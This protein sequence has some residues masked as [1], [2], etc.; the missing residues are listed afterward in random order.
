[1]IDKG[2]FEYMVLEIIRCGN[3]ENKIKMVTPHKLFRF[4]V[5]TY[6][7]FKPKNKHSIRRIEYV[8]ELGA[9]ELSVTSMDHTGTKEV[10]DLEL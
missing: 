3:F 2:R 7:K 10:Y 4:K 9:K 6:G 1:M 5:Y 8:G